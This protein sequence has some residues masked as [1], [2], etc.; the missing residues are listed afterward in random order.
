ML[1]W[2]PQRYVENGTY[3]VSVYFFWILKK[4]QI[5]KRGQEVKVNGSAG[6]LGQLKL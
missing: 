2:L 3:E 1:K 6:F 5:K 4:S